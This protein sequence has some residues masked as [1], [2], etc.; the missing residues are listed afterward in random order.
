MNESPPQIFALGASRPFG[1]RIAAALGLSLAC[2]EERSFEDGEHKSRPLENVRGRDVYVVHSLYGD[3]EQSPNDKLVRLLFFIGALRDASA[4]RITAVLPYLAYARKDRKTKSR[5]PVTTKYVASLLEAAG[6]DAAIGFDVHNLQAFQNAFRIPT[7]HL[8]ARGLF[9]DHFAGLPG[10]GDTVVMSPDAGGA[11]RAGAFRD[12]LGARLGKDLPLV[13]M[14]KTRSAG[15][16]AGE[17]VVGDVAGAAV[18]ILDDLISTGTTMA[19]AARACRARGARAVYAAAT[20][21][22]FVEGAVEAIADP[23]LS[24]VVIAD[25]V[26]PHRIEGTPA[27]DKVIVLDAAPLF[28]EAL[29]RL[30]SGGSVVELMGDQGKAGAI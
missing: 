4:R 17:S 9:V 11:K 13:F 22:L 26:P 30:H 24:S 10:A 14:E 3:A 19:R 5:D 8:S 15:V 29:R 6:A 18:V 21:G 23:A 16:V 7:D 25:S 2:H 12:A 1:E 27:R 28:A 20:H